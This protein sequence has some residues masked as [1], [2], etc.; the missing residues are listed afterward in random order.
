MIKRLQRKASGLQIQL[1]S[2]HERT[3]I[4]YGIY[5]PKAGRRIGCKAYSLADHRAL[6]A[7]FAIA[8]RLARAECFCPRLAAL[9]AA[10]SPWRD[11][12]GVLARVGIG[13]GGAGQ[14]PSYDLLHDVSRDDG[15]VRILEFP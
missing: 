5:R 1:R 8:D 6:A 13:Q 14:F 4:P 15:E 2:R 11:R 12:S 10:Q 7:L 9:P 3:G